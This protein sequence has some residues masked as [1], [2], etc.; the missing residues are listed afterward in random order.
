V[1][2]NLPSAPPSEPVAEATWYDWISPPPPAEPPAESDHGFLWPVAGRVISGFGERPDGGRNDG[3]NISAERG[4][5][6]LAAAA[7]DVTYVGN[8]LKGYGNLIL[9]RHDNGF[10]TAYAHADGVLVTRGQRVER[11]EVIASTGATGDVSR[12]QLHFE[13]RRGTRPVDPALFLV[14]REE[15]PREESPREESPRQE[16]P[17]EESPR[18][19]S[20]SERLAESTR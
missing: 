15:S 19:E 8:E 14:P 3:I 6:V 18:Q 5:P 2:S 10:T 4:T 12:P 16:S 20:L 17:R 11:G 1:D 7:G 13:L 9:I